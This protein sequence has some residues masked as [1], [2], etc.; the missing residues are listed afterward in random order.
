[1]TLV[2]DLNKYKTSLVFKTKLT[3]S[4]KKNI[5]VGSRI[6]TMMNMYYNLIKNLI[7]AG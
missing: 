5:D 6:E 1:M 3:E 4:F 2:K 7:Q